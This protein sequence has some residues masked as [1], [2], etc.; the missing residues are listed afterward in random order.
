MIAP[1]KP[2]KGRS[3][4]DSPEPITLAAAK[5][6]KSRP[7]NKAALARRRLPV[8]LPP[9]FRKR[10]GSIPLLAFPTYGAGGCE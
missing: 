8:S 9:R 3:A 6:S 10:S 4:R 7:P 2:G 1:F 5:E